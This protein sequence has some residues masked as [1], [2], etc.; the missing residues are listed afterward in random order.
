MRT[1]AAIALAAGVV[2]VGAAAG[3]AWID[4][5]TKVDHT[6]SALRQ[7][8]V[9]QTA[10][11]ANYFSRARDITL[12]AS[13]DQAFRAF[14]EQPGSL[15]A[16]RD[17]D[18]PNVAEINRQ[19]KY[20][21]TL[22]PDAV[23]EACFIDATGPE[24]ARVV[25]GRQAPIKDLSPDESG[26]IFFAA[27]F[28]L[29]GGQVYQAKPYRSPDT[30]DWV[31]SNSTPVVGPDGTNLAIAHFEIAV[32]SFRR[33]LATGGF[34]VIVI[35]R[36]SGAI[37]IDSRIPTRGAAPLGSRATAA[38]NQVV[39]AANQSPD[40]KMTFAGR[41][42]AFDTVPETATNA[43][44]WAVVALSESAMGFGLSD[45]G[46]A[47]WSLLM[48][49]LLTFAGAFV[50]YRIALRHESDQAAARAAR[51]EERRELDRL[52]T[53]VQ[54]SAVSL[55]DAAAHLETQARA[56]DRAIDEISHAAA[57]V[58]GDAGAQ[59][60]AVGAARDAAASNRERAE[61]G[62][63]AAEGVRQAMDGVRETSARLASVIGGL[64]E[65][66][67]RIGGIVQTITAIAEQTNLLAL[68]A[69][70]EAARAGDQGRGFAVVADEVRKLAEESQRSARSIT[71]LISEMQSSARAAVVTVDE[72]ASRIDEAA[73]TT[74]QT[75]ATFAE[76]ASAADGVDGA[77]V[78]IASGST[79]TADAAEA[80]RRASDESARVT[81]QILAAAGELTATAESLRDLSH[82]F[83]GRRS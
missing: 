4:H 78:D 25:R 57:T 19:L 5:G 81:E 13:Q 47:S 20:L 76:I 18:G 31:V 71:D 62:V 56:G 66:S 2:L 79:R 7:E 59:Q 39:A 67:D 54:Q 38:T 42:A 74:D 53:D 49:A 21:E 36:D 22:F 10:V 65:T 17:A 9:S 60:A 32:E 83:G 82:Q 35:D 8:V 69:A 50:T 29:N 16:R 46:A 63:S 77:L 51:D 27:T 12:I 24:I 15:I 6:E 72:A 70:I 61:E 40:G 48:L 1:I 14:Y 28:A 75:A 33:Q 58:A 68:N 26:S 37:V 3:L 52:L 64:G 73:Q 41:P 23:G 44:R 34:P 30:H 55:A 11:L 43:N 45:F 80:V